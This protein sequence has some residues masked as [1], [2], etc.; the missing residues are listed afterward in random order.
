MGV[1]VH[2][3]KLNSSTQAT[4]INLRE[5][6]QSGKIAYNVR[7]FATMGNLMLVKPSRKA[8]LKKRIII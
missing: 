6:T 2:A 8:Q 7:A 3:L 5:E 1:A 4:I